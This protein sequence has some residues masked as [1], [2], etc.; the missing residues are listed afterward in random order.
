M[1]RSYLD[2]V[3]C[4]VEGFKGGDADAR[5]CACECLLGKVESPQL[6]QQACCLQ[7][8]PNVACTAL[9]CFISCWL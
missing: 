5:Q 3:V 4:Q 9:F 7:D 6:P 2:G 8:L 1:A